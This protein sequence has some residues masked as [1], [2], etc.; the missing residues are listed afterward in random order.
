QKLAVRV[1]P[2]YFRNRDGAQYVT[3]ADD[4]LATRTYGAHYIF[5]DLDQHTISGNL[6]LNWIFSPKLSVELYMQPLVSTG[7]YTQ[8]KELEA[9]RTFDF[10]RYGVDGGSTWDREAGV[11]DPDGAGPAAPIEVGKPDFTFASLRGNAV[12]RWEW[13][14]GS[15]LFLVWTHN[16]DDS[17][18][19]GKFA[20]GQAFGD[21]MD[22]PAD[23]VLMAKLTWWWN[24]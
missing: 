19:V 22:T 10:V 9:P 20:P 1:G 11:V 5:G 24:P 13:A 14:P 17:N 23:N 6:R 4:P 7:E 2:G 18:G 21:L 15:T 16:R 8:L 12:M 3:T